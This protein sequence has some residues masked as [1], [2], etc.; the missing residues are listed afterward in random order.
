MHLPRSGSPTAPVLGRDLHRAKQARCGT[1]GRMLALRGGENPPAVETTDTAQ[2][3]VTVR[4]SSK[5]IRRAE[6]WL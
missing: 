6:R 2:T 5:T 1:L 4:R 3:V